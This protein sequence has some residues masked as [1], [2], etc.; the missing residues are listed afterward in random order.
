M[1][2]HTSADRRREH[3]APKSPGHRVRELLWRARYALLLAV[4]QDA[5]GQASVRAGLCQGIGGTRA[6]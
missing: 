1:P 3:G 4:Q 5:S 6:A 2:D